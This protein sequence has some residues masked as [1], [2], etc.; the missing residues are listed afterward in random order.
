MGKFLKAVLKLVIF[1]AVLG[2]AG[3]YVVVNHSEARQ[4]LVCNGHW[5]D[6]PHENETAYVE[7][8][9]YRPWVRLW[10]NAHGN[11]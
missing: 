11:M 10:S 6:A 5:K 8:N 3:L 4:E 7:L 2:G 9:E 1:L